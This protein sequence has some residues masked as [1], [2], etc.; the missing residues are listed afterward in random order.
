MYSSTLSLISALDWV[1]GQRTTPAALPQRET[2]CI[3]GC[4]GSMG[5]QEGYGK[6]RPPSPTELHSRNVQPV[7]IGYTD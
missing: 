3:G 4:V 5:L 1:G 7:A 2:H 6:L